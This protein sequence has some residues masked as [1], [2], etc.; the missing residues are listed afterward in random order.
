MLP[1]SPE[2]GES[3]LSADWPGHNS[4]PA[5][6]MPHSA[7]GNHELL[8]QAVCILPGTSLLLLSEFLDRSSTSLGWQPL[9]HPGILP[10]PLPELK[11][12][13]P[14]LAARPVSNIARPAPARATARV[15]L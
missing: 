3:L 14:Q 10:L 8:W 9:L 13:E 4:P 6:L 7:P 15:S 1:M 11:T 5:F 2:C 12:G